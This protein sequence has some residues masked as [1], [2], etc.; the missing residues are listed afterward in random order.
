MNEASELTSFQHIAII[1]IRVKTIIIMLYG[2]H[3]LQL[4]P[5]SF[6]ISTWVLPTLAPVAS[7]SLAAP[8]LPTTTHVPQLS[9]SW[10]PMDALNTPLL[11]HLVLHFPHQQCGPCHAL[12]SPY[13]HWFGPFCQPGLQD[14][15][16]Q[17]ISHS[18]PSRRPPH[19]QWL[20]GHQRPPTLV[21]PPHPASSASSALATFGYNCWGTISS[22]VSRPAVPQ[23]KLLGY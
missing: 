15:L 12:L 3:Q 10:Q 5:Q 20:A 9:V 1:S 11:W 17:D 21:V 8:P 6:L 22:H 19:T 16:Q 18:L 14:C 13:P 2:L 4:P 23:P 7:T